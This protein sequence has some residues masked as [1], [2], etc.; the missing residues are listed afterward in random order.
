MENQVEDDRYKNTDNPEN[1]I[2]ENI[3]DRMEHPDIRK[4]VRELRKDP[5]II[6]MLIIWGFL[7]LFRLA[8]AVK[9]TGT[10]REAPE[11]QAVNITENF[12]Y[13][14]FLRYHESVDEQGLKPLIT[15]IDNSA[16]EI[17]N[18]A[19]EQYPQ[20]ETINYRYAMFLH[21]SGKQ[22]ESETFYEEKQNVIVS[23]AIREILEEVYLSP[24]ELVLSE[25]RIIELEQSINK[26]LKSWFRDNSLL[27]LYRK[28]GSEDREQALVTSV[29][30]R[31]IPRLIILGVLLGVVGMGALLGILLLPALI[32]MTLKPEYKKL[33]LENKG[34]RESGNPLF[35]ILTLRKALLIF[36]AWEIF[37][38]FFAVFAQLV[39][40]LFSPDRTQ[41]AAMRNIGISTFITYSLIY[42]FILFIVL[43]IFREA[44]VRDFFRAI[45]VRLKSIGEVIKMSFLGLASYFAAIP[46]IVIA[47]LIYSAIF[48]H[49]AQSV[50]PVFEYIRTAG[51]LLNIVLLFLVVGIIAPIF[52][53]ILFRGIMYTSLRRY[54]PALSSTI[55]ISF[56]F[57]FIHF[58]LGVLFQ[59][60]LLGTILTVVY[61]RSGSL[62]PSIVLHCLWNSVVFI[63][64]VIMFT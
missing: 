10:Q 39:I 24:D 36:F 13:M 20:N 38:G 56:I 43:R 23:P 18:Q 35:S 55:I 1:N 25:N 6:T 16:E 54:L 3:P 53:E 60:F 64:S 48:R 47:T 33:T 49:E 32:V 30:N 29:L 51:N 50:N 15:M 62:I 46:A 58:D 21:S 4:E 14:K 9:D 31:V 22:K 27:V 42:G 28:T 61:E 11:I 57:A 45:G 41:E 12:L 19:V 37:R 2:S 5:L 26:N 44:S 59:L 8:V 17:L 40:F 7:L 63:V 34:I 52:E